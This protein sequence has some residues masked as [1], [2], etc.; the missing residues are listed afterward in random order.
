M[1]IEMDID[2]D[3][4][5][6]QVDS[7]PKSVIII[8]LLC[9]FMPSRLHNAANVL[10]CQLPIKQK[11]LQFVSEHVQQYVWCAQF[12]WKTVPCPRSLDSEAVVAV[13]RSVTWNSQ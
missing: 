12:S 13:V 10:C 9:Y 7:Q 11:C 8:I 4:S 2:V 3:N 5:S 1:A 6:L